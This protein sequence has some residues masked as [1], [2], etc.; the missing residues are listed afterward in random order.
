[1]LEV[2]IFFKENDYSCLKFNQIEKEI[3]IDYFN[4]IIFKKINI[5]ENEVLAKKY[6]IKNL[7]SLIVLKDGKTVRNFF[8]FITKENLN[9]ELNSLLN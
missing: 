3:K 8:G 2:L 4:K 7:P 6:K 9:K 5:N 1:M